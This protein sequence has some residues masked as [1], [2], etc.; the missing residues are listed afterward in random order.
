[1][2]DAA[3]SLFFV[4]MNCKSG[5]PILSEV[6]GDFIGDSFSTDE[7][8]HFG[9]LRAY[10]IKMLDE[11]SALLEIAANFDKLFDVVISGEFH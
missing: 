7:N 10:L 3:Y 8:E 6:F 1:M 4:T 9:V 2:T 5:P 11:F